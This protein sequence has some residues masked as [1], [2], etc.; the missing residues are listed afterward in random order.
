MTIAN[1]DDIAGGGLPRNFLRP[2]V[3]L[4]VSERR[5]YGYDLLERLRE[6]E[7]SSVDPGGLYRQLRG[8]ERDGLVVSDWETS[9]VGP[10]RRTYELTEEGAEWLHAWAGALAESR[11]IIGG[12][13][14][15]YRAVTRAGIRVGRHERDG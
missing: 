10:A 1:P 8:L 9:E 11:R 15:R 3:L 14:A 4:L 13:L 2:C 7:L 5:S 12:F 6:L